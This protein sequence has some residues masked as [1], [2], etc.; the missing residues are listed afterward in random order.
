MSTNNS[1]N[2]NEL[3]AIWMKESNGN[4]FYTGKLNVNG[5]EISIIMFKN[6][7]KEAG[8]KQPD[9]RI[10]RSTRQEGAPAQ[11]TGYA[12]PAAPPQTPA[13]VAAGAKLA[14]RTTVR[15]RPTNTVPAPQSQPETDTTSTQESL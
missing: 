15:P 4:K 7:R 13:P 5:E 1:K 8:S 9:W 2:P 14:G 11:K 10:Y 3:G 12:A 6:D